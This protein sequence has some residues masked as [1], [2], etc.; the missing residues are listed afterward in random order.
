M[1]V[2]LVEDDR[3]LGPAVRDQIAADGH[4][5]DWVERLDDAGDCLATVTYQLI[6]LDMMLPDGR[7]IDFLRRQR[8]R[9]DATPVIILTALDQI[10]DRIAGDG[11][12][13][14]ETSFAAMMSGFNIFL[15][16]IP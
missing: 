4:T 9:G 3:T 16:V 6:L 15:G 7:G 2:L 13:V 1:R 8:T 11:R 5:V 10:S 14:S 12:F